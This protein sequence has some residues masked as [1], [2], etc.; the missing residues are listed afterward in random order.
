MEAK[1]LNPG[2]GRHAAVLRTNRL[3]SAIPVKRRGGL[4]SKRRQV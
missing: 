2:Y 3:E 1:I 4:V